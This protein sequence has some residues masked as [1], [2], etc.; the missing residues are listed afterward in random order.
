MLYRM[1]PSKSAKYDKKKMSAAGRRQSGGPRRPENVNVTLGPAPDTA[2]GQ[3]GEL[4]FQE[5]R[6]L[7]SAVGTPQLDVR[8]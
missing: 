1:T 3:F 4:V 2:A 5:Y 6:M 8:L 7:F